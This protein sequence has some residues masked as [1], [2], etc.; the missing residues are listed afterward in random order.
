MSL[1]H[2]TLIFTT[3]ATV[4]NRPL[5]LASLSHFSHLESRS[6]GLTTG[7]PLPFPLHTQATLPTSILPKQSDI[8]MS[9]AIG[10]FK[11]KLPSGNI[12]ERLKVQEGEQEV[13][14]RI[15]Q[16]QDLLS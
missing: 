8:N 2:F 15:D 1:I 10:S 6:S 13:N 9:R 12:A 11:I 7:S 4:I 3:F 14:S 5:V 16:D